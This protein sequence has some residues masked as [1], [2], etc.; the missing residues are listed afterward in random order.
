MADDNSTW[1]NKGIYLITDGTID[2][3]TTASMRMHLCKKTYTPSAQGHDDHT[4]LTL[5][6]A[7][8]YVTTGKALKAASITVTESSDGA[9]YFDYTG[10]IVWTALGNG[11]NNSIR[12][13][14][15]YYNDSA[16][17]AGAGKLLACLDFGTSNIKSTNGS[18]FKVTINA[19]GIGKIA[20][21]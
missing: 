15:V 14:V 4:D 20:T 16:S 10:S 13:A 8:S 19:S 3:D 5:C 17:N 18:D 1:Y 21:S 9:V 6:D 12:Y 11:T 2:L 7:T